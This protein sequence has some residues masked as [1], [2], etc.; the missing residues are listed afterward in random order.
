[1][2]W[3]VSYLSDDSCAA[4]LLRDPKLGTIS[5][6]SYADMLI[7]DANP[8]ADVRILDHPEKH[9]LVVIKGGIVHGS[10]I[11]QLSVQVAY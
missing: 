4:R 7:L 6:G 3:H 10:R 8:L 11:E 9:L 2:K 5:A 1:M